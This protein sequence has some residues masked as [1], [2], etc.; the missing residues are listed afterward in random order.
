VMW[1][2]IRF[3]WRGHP[4]K[5]RF[6]HAEYFSLYEGGTPISESTQLD[7]IRAAGLEKELGAIALEKAKQGV[8]LDVPR[9]RPHPFVGGTQIEFLDDEW[10]AAMSGVMYFAT[11]KH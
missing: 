6:S 10:L 7:L 11:R 5:M 4:K 8:W 9:P 1:I 3:S 2:D